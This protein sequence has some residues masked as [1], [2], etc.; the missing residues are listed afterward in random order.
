M[1][2][3]IVGGIKLKSGGEFGG[4]KFIVR[5]E[6]DST[7]CSDDGRSEFG[8]AYIFTF[9]SAQPTPPQSLGRITLS[10]QPPL[11]IHQVKIELL[12]RIL[13]SSNVDVKY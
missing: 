13:S 10:N 1:L 12:Y 11:T 2:V 4:L 8:G 9:K 6:F 7:L 5:R 3:G